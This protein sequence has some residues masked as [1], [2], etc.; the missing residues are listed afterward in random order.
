MPLGRRFKRWGRAAMVTVVGPAAAATLLVVSP[1]AHAAEG[2]AAHIAASSDCEFY[3]YLAEGVRVDTLR[4]YTYAL[5]AGDLHFAS[6]VV[7][8]GRQRLA[9][10]QHDQ[11]R[12]GCP[13]TEYP[14]FPAA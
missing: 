3:A 4:N 13:V 7:H 1:P 8:L 9:V 11:R 14:H 6:E 2:A 10:V 5:A 12:R